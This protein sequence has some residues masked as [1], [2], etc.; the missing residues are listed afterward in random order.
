MFFEKGN[1]RDCEKS[2]LFCKV[3]MRSSLCLNGV[4]RVIMESLTAKPGLE[5]I[6]EVDKRW[7]EPCS[8]TLRRLFC[9]NLN[10]KP[11]EG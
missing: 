8:L 4:I 6:R 7:D 1:L 3:R 9:S 10:I 2:V 11:Y 5:F